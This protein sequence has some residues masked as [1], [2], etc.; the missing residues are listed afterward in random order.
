MKKSIQSIITLCL[1]AFLA[2][3]CK[4]TST[5]STTKAPAK[6]E[7]L[8]NSLLWKIS[9]NGLEKPSYLY[10]TVHMTCNYKLTEK[11]KTAFAE[12]SQ[13]AL[14]VDMDDPAMPMKAM[15]GMMMKG[16]ASIK[17]M[18]SAEDYKKL[19][20]YFTKNTGMGVAMLN[21]AKPFMLMSLLLSKST[22]CEKP[23]S[24]ED[25][26]VKIAKADKEEVLG[27]ETIESQLALFDVIPYDVQLKEVMKM[28]NDGEEETK[29]QFAELSALHTA[30][31]I[32][33]LMKMMQEEE[34]MTKDFSDKLLDNRN[35][36]W[37]PVIEKM[38]K[39]KP[40]FYGIGAMHLSGENGVIKLL[41]KAGYT[42]TAVK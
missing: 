10:G 18:L 34:G 26:F 2:V 37:I 15:Q 32:E 30:E 42:V 1:V 6:E 36:N 24:Y 8:A 21:K 4:S 9:G 7:K 16:D 19:D 35:K 33:G 11:L 14:E 29:K 5:A 13:I 41:R 27:L 31:N 22:G 17:D 23:T 12:T 39:E 20:T 28:V 38:S 3:S 40:T 25:E